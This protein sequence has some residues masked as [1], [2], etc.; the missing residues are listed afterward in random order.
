M[1]WA[2]IGRDYK[3][4]LIV[5]PKST[6]SFPFQQKGQSNWYFMQE[7]AH[8][9]VSKHTLLF[10][11]KR[12]G[13]L[14]NWSANSPDLNPIEH[15]WPILKYIMREKNPKSIQELVKVITE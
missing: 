10:L 1:V 2:T 12:M 13:L 14:G 15:S 11:D 9:Y 6:D 7:G 4:R 5:S 8:P 3:S